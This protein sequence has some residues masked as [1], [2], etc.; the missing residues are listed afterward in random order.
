M[1]QRALKRSAAANSG[2][3]S[4]EYVAGNALI[5]FPVFVPRSS[6]NFRRKSG[7]WGLLVPTD[8]LEIIADILLVEG[9]LG[10]ARRVLIA[11]PE[12]RRI[13]REGLIN[14]NELVADQPQFKFCVGNDD[15]A[16]RGVLN[17][18]SVNGEARIAQARCQRAA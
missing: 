11:R 16:R 2:A 5:C 14:P 1:Q 4:I 18:T 7:P 17:S 8:A 3:L 9:R 6:D 12:A 15:A 13:G 10:I